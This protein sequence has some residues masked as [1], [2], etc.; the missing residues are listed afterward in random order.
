M[1]NKTIALIALL[2][3]VVSACD[4][5]FLDREPLSYVTPE[6][7]ETEDDVLLAVNGTY[8]ALVNADYTNMYPIYT[9]FMTDNGFMDKSWSGEVEFWDQ[10]Q[11]PNSAWAERKWN[12]NYAGVLRANTV[13]SVI[14]DI[15]MDSDL[16]AQY[17]GE[18][19]FLRALYYSDLIQFYGDVPYRTEPEGIEDQ[20]APRVDEDLIREDI[21]ADLD[22]AAEGLPTTY[23][24]TDL[25][26]ATKGAALALKARI[27]LNH[28]EWAAAAAA[29]QAVIDLG[30]YSLY[31]DYQELFLPEGEGNSEMIFDV[32]YI[33]NQDEDDLT[34]PWYTYFFAWSS[35][36]A[37]ADLEREYYMDNGL[38]IDDPASGYDEDDPW[39]DRD[40]RLDYTLCVPYSFDG[41]SK[42]GV[43]KTYIPYSKKSDNFSSLRIRKWVDYGD[44]YVHL[45]S[46][47]N[48]IIIRYADVLLMRA[49][50]LV[51]TG[52]Y[53]INE[54]ISL[55]DEVRSRTSV[56]MPTVAEV[57][58]TALDQDA[59]RQLI[60]HERRVEFAFEGTRI[61]DIKR[62]NIGEDVLVNAT[63][64]DPDYLTTSSTEYVLYEFRDR[65]F[66]T[67][68]G[69]LWPIPIS[70]MNTNDAI[71][72]NNDGY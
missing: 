63:G 19:L 71:T 1:K 53:D 41:Y 13:L 37:L 69:Y 39:T 52:S 72:G 44:D 18:V 23:E 60:R 67:E 32:Q 24:D 64:Y 34:S 65:T 66:N 27:L 51:E 17:R 20:A 8:K 16:K 14:D 31:D 50:A 47:V 42:A 43:A 36:M 38:S 9:D 2:T 56:D 11:T 70:E 46:A 49:E 6:S 61:M 54:V 57:E 29:C 21:L 22:T 33:A 35:Y 68:K 4:D 3:V 15:T 40:P 59:L 28:E 5:G 55:V 45:N 62:W 48:N 30:V 58:G 7:I 25:G 12:R 10:V 26:R